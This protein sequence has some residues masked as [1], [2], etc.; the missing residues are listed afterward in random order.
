MSDTLLIRFLERRLQQLRNGD[1]SFPLFAQQVERVAATLEQESSKI[2][3]AARDIWF[4]IEMINALLLDDG[5][6]PGPMD[7]QDTVQLVRK[8]ISLLSSVDIADDS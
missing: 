6:P 3:R 2:S 4:Q 5:R 1:L 8:L 7:L